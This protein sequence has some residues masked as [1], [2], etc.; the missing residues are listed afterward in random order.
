[1]L[2]SVLLS[3]MGFAAAVLLAACGGR[4]DTVT[5]DFYERM[6]A[7]DIAGME[8]FVCE[9]ERSAFR[10]SVGFLQGMSPKRALEVHDFVARTERSDGTSTTMRVSGQFV[11]AEEVSTPL[12]ARVQLV[13]EGSEWCLSGERA[14][15]REVRDSAVVVYGMVFWGGISTYLWTGGSVL[16][17]VIIVE[18]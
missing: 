12:S 8:Q 15:F 1:M 4:P 9:E 14:G 5:R 3:V 16:R 10:G 17:S 6:A 2:K 11:N 7:L 13:R 18:D